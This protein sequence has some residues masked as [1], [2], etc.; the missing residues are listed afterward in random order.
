ML[1]QGGSL[2]DALRHM[3]QVREQEVRGGARQ[4]TSAPGVGQVRVEQVRHEKAPPGWVLGIDDNGEAYYFSPA[5][6]QT[7]SHHPLSAPPAADTDEEDEDYEDEEEEKVAERP[8]LNTVRLNKLVA[9]S[10]LA[11][12]REAEVLIAEGRVT[13]NGAVA[14]KSTAVNAL[15]DTVMVDGARLPR[16]KDGRKLSP[17]ERP[18]VWAVHKLSG[19]LVSA[20]D[21]RKRP[22]MLDRVKKVV[23]LEGGASLKPV[24]HLEYRTEGLCL[25]SNNGSLSRFLGSKAGLERTYRVRVHGLLTESKLKAL[26][27]GC[28]VAGVKQ[29]GM[30]VRIDRQ[31]K[32]TISWLSLVVKDVSVKT[33]RAVLQQLHVRAL[34]ILCVRVGPFALDDIPQGAVQELKVPREVLAAWQKA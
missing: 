4:A 1:T 33:I 11:S 29:P 18:R 31:G 21:A 3:S 27:M 8:L 28:V 20:Q 17:A 32:S 13:V 23:P 19:E 16:P 26:R 5:T 25:V 2:A 7:L 6:G 12:R 9:N 30:Q 14:G 22:L 34:R 15:L 24:D 10:G